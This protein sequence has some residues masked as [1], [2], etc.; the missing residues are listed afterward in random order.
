MKTCDEAADLDGEADIA[1][2][3]ADIVLL[4]LAL[5]S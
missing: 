2:R 1:D 4:A 3:R 5:D